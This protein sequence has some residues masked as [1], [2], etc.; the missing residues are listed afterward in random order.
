[1]SAQSAVSHGTASMAASSCASTYG[2]KALP[3]PKSASILT[4]PE[5]RALVNAT[6][7]GGNSCKSSTNA[8]RAY[9]YGDALQPYRQPAVTRSFG[10]N[11]YGEQPQAYCANDLYHLPSTNSYMWWRPAPEQLH[12]YYANG[13]ADDQVAHGPNPS[14]L[15]AAQQ[16][17]AAA[18]NLAQAAPVWA[19]NHRPAPVPSQR[20][21]ASRSRGTGRGQPPKRPHVRTSSRRHEDQA[22]MIRRAQ[23]NVALAPHLLDLDAEPEQ[24]PS[25][26][27]VD[28]HGAHDERA[29]RFHNNSSAVQDDGN[30]I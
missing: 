22:M 4:S 20:P 13:L 12:A 8:A 17:L 15:L 19:V 16:H 6:A 23:E 7:C 24:R 10:W 18:Q 11:L 27:N 30:S 21:F 28:D 14:A 25:P 2:A 1:M 26:I 29:L 5:R 9:G 3:R